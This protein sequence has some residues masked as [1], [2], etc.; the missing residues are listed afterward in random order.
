MTF[1]AMEM[2]MAMRMSR[3]RECLRAPLRLGPRR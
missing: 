1:M 3:A 2:E